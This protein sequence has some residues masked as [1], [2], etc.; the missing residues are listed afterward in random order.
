MKPGLSPACSALIVLGLLFPASAVAQDGA[1]THT[2]T[3]RTA[4]NGNRTSRG[5]FPCFEGQDSEQSRE[6]DNEAIA[7]LPR[8]ARFWLTEDVAYL[9]SPEERC[10]FLQLARDEERNQF[11]EQFWSRRAPDPTSFDNSFK[12]A[13]YERIAFSDE[14]YGTQV[15]GWKTDRGRIYVL[16]GPPDSVES[17]RSGE[18]TGRPRQAGVATYQYSWEAWHYGHLEGV[19]GNLE[20]EFVDPGET[21]DYRLAMP[22]E[23]KDELIFAPRYNLGRSSRG[24]VT[25]ESAQS[26]D[27][28]I[29]PTPTP[30]VHFKDLEAIVVSQILRDQVRFSHRI[31]FSKSNKRSDF[32][33]DFRL[34]AKRATQCLGQ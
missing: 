34:P 5:T 4:L 19:G 30:L 27:P 2:D 16:F 9:I 14:K 31:E 6:R 11:I 20:L 3:V 25:P 13:H 23:M 21:G 1:S 28:Y 7:N 33:A 26:I 10:S 8:L 18:K 24:G 32:G 22:P 15:P 12:R 17:H 29:G